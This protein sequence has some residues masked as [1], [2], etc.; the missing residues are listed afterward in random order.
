MISVSSKILWGDHVE[1]VL[2][3]HQTKEDR[4]CE[5]N[6]AKSASRSA[7]LSQTDSVRFLDFKMYM[8]DSRKGIL[9]IQSGV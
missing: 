9:M 7:F 2:D 5:I 3:G 6:L 1:L 8:K 4:S